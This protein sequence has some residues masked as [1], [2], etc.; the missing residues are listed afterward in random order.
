MNGRWGYPGFVDQS[1]ME[2]NFKHVDCHGIFQIQS[3]L[4]K[5]LSPLRVF[6]DLFIRFNSDS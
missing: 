3:F 6:L 5:V 1:T 2:T 4:H